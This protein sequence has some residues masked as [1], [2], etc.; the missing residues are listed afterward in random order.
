MSQPAP[1][2]DDRDLEALSAQLRAL[3]RQLVRDPASADD[4]VQEAWLASLDQPRGAVRELGAWLRT[5]VRNL[6]ARSARRDALRQVAHER[7]A[8]VESSRETE[9]MLE[10]SNIALALR[11]AAHELAEPVRS[12]I[13]LH[14]FEGRTLEATA[15]QLG[16]PLETVRSQRRRGI[17]EL[18]GVL[19]RRHRGARRDWLAALAPLLG[20][21]PA[22]TPRWRW[23]ALGALA[24]I[25]VVGIG[26][27]FTREKPTAEPAPA[28]ASVEAGTDDATE[29]SVEVDEAPARV[30]VAP[31]APASAP[32]PPS[33]PLE[34]PAVATKRFAARVTD[35]DGAPVEGARLDVLGLNGAQLG[36]FVTDAQGRAAFELRADQ[37]SYRASFAERGGLVVHAF[38]P[39]RAKSPLALVPAIEGE[40][41]FELSLGGPSQALSG[42]VVDPDGAP[43]VDAQ[44]ELESE[45]KHM[46][47]APGGVLLLE[48]ARRAVSGAD[49]RFTLDHLPRR[50]HRWVARARD[51]GVASDVIEG[52]ADVLEVTIALPRGVEITGVVSA[53]NGAPAANAEVW[54]ARG[55]S[56][57]LLAPR[58]R[59]DERGRY[60]LRGLTESPVRIFVRAAS[61]VDES[62]DA[63]HA[64]ADGVER[65]E[66]DFVLSPHPALEVR[67][68]EADGRPSPAGMV[69]LETVPGAPAPWRQSVSTDADGRARWADYPRAPL[70]AQF[71]PASASGAALRRDFDSRDTTTLELRLGESEREST[72]AV[73]LALVDPWHAPIQA[74]LLAVSSADGSSLRADVDPRTGVLERLELP[75]GEREFFAVDAFGVTALGAARLDG[76]S[77]LDLGLHT[78]GA[79]RS[80][81][82]EWALEGGAGL[83]WMVVGQLSANCGLERLLE[84]AHGRTRF[85]LRD[86]NYQL[87]GRSATGDDRFTLPFTVGDGHPVRVRV[88]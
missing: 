57:N 63:L 16:R 62:A 86:G 73:S 64:F 1:A 34:A 28:L 88:K 85:E 54:V 46:T 39:G 8:A 45:V 41:E 87:V 83:T 21:G 27:W 22:P 33:E 72:S 19:D 13:V 49:G 67:C 9:E 51:L 80:I 84:F 78:L 26:I 82:V 23:T 56:F 53:S 2:P 81:D 43:L 50:P 18:R 48:D 25:A 52:D 32:Q 76:A 35:P 75:A 79:V 12:V 59:T 36:P 17:D 74:R 38:A 70:L 3:A 77:A 65:S 5:V 40:Q 68:L 20:D 37:L 11:E 4:L 31:Q 58:A 60:R 10:R 15:E 14:Y 71:V 30:D 42:L 24:A 47:S 69:V 29:S 66:L 6:A 55:V 44:I 61:G 7:S